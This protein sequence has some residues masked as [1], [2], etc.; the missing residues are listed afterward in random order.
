M[1]LKKSLAITAGLLVSFSSAA[2]NLSLAFNNDNIDLGYELELQQALKLKGDYLQT[3]DNG[4]TLDTGLYAFQDV[5]STFFELGAKGMMMHTDFGEGSSIA[6][7][8]LAGP[9][10]TEALSLETELH[11]SPE[12]LAFGDT[13]NYTQWIAR[14]SYAVMPTAH[15]FVEYNSTTIEYDKR[16]DEDLTG[17]VLVGL[18]WVF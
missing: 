18:K 12:I 2:S 4:F 15:F 13:N 10:L 3:I 5:G 6:F 1:S 17:D 11:F 16:P 14:V 8:G 7:G 9:R